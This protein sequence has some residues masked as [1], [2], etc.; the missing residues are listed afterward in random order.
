MK[1]KIPLLQLRMGDC[2]RQ[3]GDTKTALIYY[4]ELL[5]VYPKSSE[6]ALA[7]SYVKK[8]EKKQG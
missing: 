3:L 7:S 2:F 4:N 5:A 6:A 1:D 8:L